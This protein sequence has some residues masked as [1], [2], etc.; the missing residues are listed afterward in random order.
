M[1]INYQSVLDRANVIYKNKIQ[2][3]FKEKFPDLDMNRVNLDLQED[4]QAMFES[5]VEEINS[6]K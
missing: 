1:K 6:Q 2:E 4:I 3:K 5:L